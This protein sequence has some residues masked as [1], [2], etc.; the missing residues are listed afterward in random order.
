MSF[1]KSLPSG[2]SLV[3]ASFLAHAVSQD[4]YTVRGRVTP[5]LA[6]ELEREYCIDVKL[7]AHL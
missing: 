1:P 5:I 6:H 3:F 2:P 4:S 7:N